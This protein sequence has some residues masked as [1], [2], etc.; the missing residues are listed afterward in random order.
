MINLSIN[1]KD[2]NRKRTYKEFTQGDESSGS[3]ASSAQ[4]HRNGSRKYK[5]VEPKGGLATA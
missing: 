5:K 3:N 4:D 2:A 1:S